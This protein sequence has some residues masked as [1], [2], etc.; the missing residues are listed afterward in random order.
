M[1]IL[2]ITGNDSVV[3]QACT[4]NARPEEWEFGRFV[5]WILT[6]KGDLPLAA[7]VTPPSL[8][9][10]ASWNF[11]SIAELWFIPQTLLS[12]LS[13]AISSRPEFPV[14]NYPS[15]NY[16][17]VNFQTACTYFSVLVSYCEILEFGFSYISFRSILRVLKESVF[18]TPFPRN[19]MSCNFNNIL[20][21]PLNETVL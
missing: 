18:L 11:R 10:S 17:A 9:L 20:N 12:L 1:P 6:E 14:C 3:S 4:P 21:D 5:P 19:F 16:R 13:F 8:H 2:R 15:R 7:L